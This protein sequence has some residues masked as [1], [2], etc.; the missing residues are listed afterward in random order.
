MTSQFFQLPT[1]KA[2]MKYLG[3]ITPSKGTRIYTRAA[4]GMPGSTEHL[5]ELMYRILG[6][7]MYEGVLVKIANDIYIRGTTVNSLFMNWK[8]ALHLFWKNNLR[9]SAPKTVICPITTTVLGWIWSAGDISV[10]P[11]KINPLATADPPTTTKGLWA[12]I[13]AYKHIKAC[14]PGYSALLADLEGMVAGKDSQEHFSWSDSLITK[15]R[16]AQH[17]LKDPKSITIPRP[18]DHLLI[19]S[20]ASVRNAGGY[21]A[22]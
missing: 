11:H 12:W 14:I 22:K 16:T 6:Y 2:S 18:T 5:D 9:L 4:M 8:R 21:L 20:D 3:V 19:T 15:F 10:S 7:F 1:K 17:V 13:G